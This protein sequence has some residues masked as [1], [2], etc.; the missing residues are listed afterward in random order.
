MELK[1]V[2]RSLVNQENQNPEAVG[3]DLLPFES[4]NLG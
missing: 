2:I 4:A 1:T 3:F